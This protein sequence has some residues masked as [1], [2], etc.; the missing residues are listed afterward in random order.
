[1]NNAFRERARDS[2]ATLAGRRETAD[3]QRRPAPWL[4]QHPTP[5]ARPRQKAGGGP[6]SAWLTGL[7]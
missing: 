2:Y 7:S 6:A 1:L 4:K 3:A 5:K